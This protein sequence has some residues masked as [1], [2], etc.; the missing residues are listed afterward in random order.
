MRKNRANIRLTN[1]ADD[2]DPRIQDLEAHVRRMREMLPLLDDLVGE[3]LLE[4]YDAR[5][6]SAVRAQRLLQ[7]TVRELMNLALW[8]AGKNDVPPPAAKPRMITCD[9]PMGDFE[10]LISDEALLRTMRDARFGR[11]FTRPRKA[12]SRSDGAS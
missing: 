9:D 1:S 8:L 10:R 11:P 6:A 12:K 3:T 5:H 7:E 2:R 4:F